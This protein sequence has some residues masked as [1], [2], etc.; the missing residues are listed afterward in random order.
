MTAT[1]IAATATTATVAAAIT[2]STTTAAAT[3]TLSYT[4]FK[5]VALNTTIFI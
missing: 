4:P 5:R 3:T 2:T 1:D